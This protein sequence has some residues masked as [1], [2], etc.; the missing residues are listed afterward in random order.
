M[1][2]RSRVHFYARTT[3][4]RCRTQ[5]QWF[6]VCLFYLLAPENTWGLED[7]SV[8]ESCLSVRIRIQI[9]RSLIEAVKVGGFGSF[10][11]IPAQRPKRWRQRTSQRDGYVESETPSFTFDE[12]PCLNI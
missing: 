2:E 5:T 11:V 3:V 1:F 10:P 7:G 9:P 6:L 4:Q 12:R 8:G